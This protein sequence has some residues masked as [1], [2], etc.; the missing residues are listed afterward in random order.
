MTGARTSFPPV[1]R[2]GLIF[3][4]SV[5]LFLAIAGGI[6][7]F[8]S[9][10]EGAT[11]PVLP[12]MLAAV[13]FLVPLPLLIYQGYSLYRAQYVLERDGLSILWGLRAESMPL[14]DIEWIRPADEL[15]F[16]LP[17]PLIRWPGAL[18][19]SRNVEGLGEVEFIASGRQ[20]LLL[21]AT[22]EKVIAISPEDPKGFQRTFQRMVELGSLSPMTTYSS[23]AVLFWREVL[24]NRMAKGL[25]IGGLALNFL[26]LIS[27]ALRVTSQPRLPMGYDATGNMRAAGP[28]ER[29]L[30]FP[31]LSMLIYTVDVLAGMFFFRR[32]EQKTL[33]Y[34]TWAGFLIPPLLFIVLVTFLI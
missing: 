33:A 12:W 14:S 34:F 24:G 5:S 8:V 29:L 2:A 27:V 17:L 26:L 19:G 20:N 21:L 22:P 25:L 11:T 13:V 4:G 30:L 15:G 10:E 16:H 23:R 32:H 9:L 7:L 31:I 18:I 28:S 1:R 6:C 3:H